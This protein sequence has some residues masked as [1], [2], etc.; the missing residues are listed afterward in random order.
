MQSGT[1]TSARRWLQNYLCSS[2]I[3]L[4]FLHPDKEE[5]AAADN[6][7]TITVP[8]F[9]LFLSKNRRAEN[10]SAIL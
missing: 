3:L 1:I 10:D 4:K 8:Q 5:A 7:N 2:V 6:N 9:F